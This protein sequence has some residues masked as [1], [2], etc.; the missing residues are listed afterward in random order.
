[1]QSKKATDPDI[2][3]AFK[4]PLAYLEDSQRTK[5]RHRA[6]QKAF[7][8]IGTGVACAILLTFLDSLGV[9]SPPSYSNTSGSG[10]FLADILAFSALLLPVYGLLQLI[11]LRTQMTDYARAELVKNHPSLTKLEWQR[12]QKL[13]KGRSNF[14]KIFTFGFVGVVFV[15]LVLLVAYISFRSQ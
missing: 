4:K 5:F 12:L 15:A 7:I 11:M 1:M 2:V 13:E 9:L 3:K 8:C 14:L 6:L 10:N